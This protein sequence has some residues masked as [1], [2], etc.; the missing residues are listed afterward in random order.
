MEIKLAFLNLVSTYLFSR[1]DHEDPYAHLDTVYELCATIGF[2]VG[3]KEV[4][5]MKLFPFSLI[6]EAKE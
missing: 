2:D 6:G 5:Y 1:K 3:Q 4:I